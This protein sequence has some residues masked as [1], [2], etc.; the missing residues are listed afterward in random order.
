MSI[1]YMTTGHDTATTGKWGGPKIEEV[2]IIKTTSGSVW[3][4]QRRN[5]KRSGYQNFFENRDEAVAFLR[6]CQELRIEYH[7]RLIAN[8]EE[9]LKVLA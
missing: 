7:R 6:E 2:E 8:H 9:N 5:A 3:V 4:G 1:W